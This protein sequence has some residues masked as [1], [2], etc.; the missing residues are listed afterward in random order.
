MKLADPILIS[1]IIS[2]LGLTGQEA[3]TK[4]Q[5]LEK[6]SNDELNKLIANVSS[7]SPISLGGFTAL[8]NQNKFSG[9]VFQGNFVDNSSTSFSTIQSTQP[10][11]YTRVQ[12][13][14]LDRFLGDF[15]Y[16]SASSGL[17]E[18]TAYNNSI[19]T[20][21]ITDRAVNGFKV[22]TGQQDRIGLQEQMTEEV[23][24]AQKLKKAAYSQPGAFES[25][26]ERKFGV[27]YSHSNVEQLKTAS[28]EFTRVSVYHDKT[29]LLEQGFSEVKNI[30]REEQ[31]YAQ[32][33]KYVRGTAA[34]SLIPPE[35][36]SHEKFGEVLLQFCNG[37]KNLVNEYMKNLSS[38]MGS[39]VEIEKNLPQIMDELIA[40]SK[41]QEQEALGGKSFSQ[42]EQE[43][44]TACKKVFG[45]K[46]YKE[47][48]QNFVSNAKTQAAYTEMGLT[49]A[50]SLLLPGSSVVKS[51]MQKA[52]LKYGEKTAVQGFKAAMTVGAASMPATLSTLNAATSEEGFTPE[53]IAE[54]QEKFKNGL[55]YGGFGAYASGP[56]GNAVEKVLSK[57]PTML[58]N[59]V[60]KTMG[61]AT[62]TSA[63]VLF[64]RITSDL[65]FTESLK[66]NGVMNFG[67]MIAGGRI[68]KGSDNALS[69]LKVAKNN[70]GTYSVKDQSG[71]VVFKAND[72]NAL[73]G[74]VLE[75]GIHFELETHLQ[76]LPLQTS[77]L[78]VSNSIISKTPINLDPISQ[79]KRK[80]RLEIQ[81]IEVE[82]QKQKIGQELKIAQKNIQS[83]GNQELI[84]F[85]DKVA[86]DGTLTAKQIS[87]LGDLAFVKDDKIINE[88]ISPSYENMGVDMD[89]YKIQSL[90]EIDLGLNSN[91]GTLNNQ[92]HLAVKEAK[93]SDFEI[94]YDSYNFRSDEKFTQLKKYLGSYSNTNAELSKYL[95]EKYYLKDKPKDVAKLSKSIVDKY[96]TFVFLRNSDDLNFLKVTE[97]VFSNY[98]TASSGTAKYPSCLDFTQYNKNFVNGNASGITSENTVN[99]NGALESTLQHEMMHINDLNVNN[100]EFGDVFTDELKNKYV[101]ELRNMG[102][103]EKDIEYAHTSVAEYLA[104]IAGCGDLNKCSAEFK[105]V[106]VNKLEMPEWIFN[107][108]Q[109]SITKEIADTAAELNAFETCEKEFEN[110]GRIKITKYD[111]NRF[112]FVRIKNS[113]ITPVAIDKPKDATI[114][115]DYLGSLKNANGTQRFTPIHI[116]RLLKCIN[117]ENED[118]AFKLINTNYEV[119]EPGRPR[120]NIYD[121]T[122]IL[123]KI[124]KNNSGYVM[125]L[126]DAKYPNGNPKYGSSMISLVLPV[127]N[128]NWFDKIENK[129]IKEIRNKFEY[130]GKL[131]KKEDINDEF[132]ADLDQ[133]IGMIQNEK[134]KVYI[135]NSL[136]EVL[137][138]DRYDTF[139]T[140]K[141]FKEISDLADAINAN[142]RSYSIYKKSDG[143]VSSMANFQNFLKTENMTLDDVLGTET[144]SQDVFGNS[145]KYLKNDLRV[146][147]KN[148]GIKEFNK[149]YP[150]SKMADYL[151]EEIYLKKWLEKYP[152][153]ENVKNAVEK[154]KIINKKFNTKIYFGN[155]RMSSADEVLNYVDKELGLWQKASDGAAKMPPVIDFSSAKSA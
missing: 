75:R 45:T 22:L 102:I 90:I 136:K 131:D 16:N 10:K 116:E 83:T 134:V 118:I 93:K 72:E 73:A 53:K 27:P 13:K 9:N 37:D 127:R 59:I 80:K 46:G 2:S 42:Y 84:N 26:I 141:I 86:K 121:L 32:A 98:D 65:S 15:L 51:G 120:F 68:A 6:L 144:H 35:I 78:Q 143:R 95:Y 111:D 148:Y 54:I 117:E 132:L 147:N 94:D 67:M 49:I 103:S 57:N 112:D 139:K 142:K 60:G 140:P 50:T 21:N 128:S 151:Y 31:E 34:A 63:D 7:Y 23:A 153:N 126:V 40:K 89:F 130:L 28:E 5:E 129:T 97:K 12:Q 114:T 74:F 4:R 91:A 14:E 133:R 138:K 38:S 79:I 24:E 110:Y 71:S 3:E 1:Q 47:T 101:D 106:L 107:L 150:N 135:E 119:G 69:S 105:D 149:D 124:N 77:D 122:D 55:V 39:R 99:I 109:S 33:K 137:E 48:A 64:D 66:Q 58:S 87:I 88:I 82:S 19:G 154:A 44:N 146:E 104:V 70:D 30:L 62:E 115:A 96:G 20:L 11:E 145:L 29:E 85:F 92:L 56:L 43:Y 108:K 61:T 52:A 41:A 125:E 81:K 25:K 113:D 18:I 155:N 36:S 123:S 100:F 8:E 152:D 76:V 17:Q